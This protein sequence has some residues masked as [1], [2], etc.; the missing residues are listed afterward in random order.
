MDGLR[1]IA[2]LAVVFYH[3]QLGC[4]GGFVGV[5]VFF[6]I[7]GYLITRIL[8]KDLLAGRFSVIKF[9]QRRIRRIFPALFVVIFTTGAIGLRFLPPDELKDLGKCI[10]A[11]SAFASN[12]LFFRRSGYFDHSSLIQPLLHTWTLSIEEQFYIFW[13]WFLALLQIPSLRRRKFP[14]VLLLVA[15]SLGLSSFWVSNKPLAAFYLLPSRAFELAIGALLSISPVPRILQRLPRRLADVASLAGFA[16]ILAAIFLYG[17]HVGFPGVAALLPTLGAAL[18][19]GSGEGGPTIAGRIL[20]L[21]PFVWIGLISYSLYLW[22]WPILVFARLF[23]FGELGRIGSVFCVVLSIVVAWFSWWLIESPFRNPNVLGGSSRTWVVGGL[24]TTALFLV[25]GLILDFGAGFPG[26]SPKVAEWLAQETQRADVELIHSPCMSWNALL[27]PERGCVLNAAGPGASYNVALW[28]DSNGAHLA[29]AF[30]Q[31][32]KRLAIVTR[33][34]T[35]AGC[36]PVM[37]VRFLPPTEMTVDCPAFD[38]NVLRS[39]LADPHVRVVILAA[40]W[41]SLASGLTAAPPYRGSANAAESRR[42]FVEGLHN[43]VTKLIESGRQVVLVSQVPSPQLNPIT[44]LARAR[45]NG[46][47]ESRCDSMPADLYAAEED[48]IDKAL[49]DAA[50]NL[51]NVQ[52]VH[53]MDVLCN[54]ISCRLVDHGEPLYWD[55][56][57]LSDAGAKLLGPQLEVSMRRA[58]LSTGNLGL[59]GSD[60]IEVTTKPGFE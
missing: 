50:G 54:N 22:H 16:M 42:L 43:T 55:S 10:V 14:I 6:V 21:G 53:P 36:P 27:P 8:E 17:E 25:F 3:T 48:R 9:Y 23:F 40:R 15:G 30:A 37:D 26:R 57:H 59:Q 12:I 4:P 19:I 45:F 11:A 38:R 24:A 47:N 1:A 31:I 32:D 18:V 56:T 20:S 33:E 41:N 44:C 51:P 39:I 7:S 28:G 13:P 34:M 2:V 29:P 49:K 58:L 52:I 60:Q 35:K 46:W 5:D